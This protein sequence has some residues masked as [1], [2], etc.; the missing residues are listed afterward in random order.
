MSDIVNLPI[1]LVSV[2]ALNLTPGPDTAL[3]LHRS[4][5]QGRRAGI[6]AVLGITTG[7]SVHILASAFGL[8]ALLAASANAFLAIKLAGACYLAWLGWKMLRSPT[9]DAAVKTPGD[10]GAPAGR[11]PLPK[12]SSMR[13]VFATGFLTNVLN[14]KVALFF[15]AFFPQFVSPHAHNKLAAFLSLGGIFAAMSTVWCLALALLAVLLKRGV[16]RRPGLSRIANRLL[17]CAFI[18]L[19]VRLALTRR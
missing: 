4:A 16:G 17:A 9:G 1:F 7:C 2:L 8:T 13:R 14:P 15:L 3:I 10:S 6:V 5:T 11:S 18:G 12:R 19:G